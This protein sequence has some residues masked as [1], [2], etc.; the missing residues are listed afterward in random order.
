MRLHHWF[1]AGVLISASAC[2]FDGSTDYESEG[3]RVGD[4]VQ[5]DPTQNPPGPEPVP[6]FFASGEITSQGQLLEGSYLDVVDLDGNTEFILAEIQSEVEKLEHRWDFSALPAGQYE[7]TFVAHPQSP[8]DQEYF[9]VDFRLSGSSTRT[10]IMILPTGDR[11]S[12]FVGRVDLPADADVEIR[13]RLVDDAGVLDEPSGPG[14]GWWS[15]SNGNDD[16]DDKPSPYR[17]LEVDFVRLTQTN[18]FTN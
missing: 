12:E 6:T 17:A 8:M 4:P 15:A 2:A 11:M 5:G 3:R 7:L 10:Q 18:L 9:T 13:A 1:F 16:D 14:M